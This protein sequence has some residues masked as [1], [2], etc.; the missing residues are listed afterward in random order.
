[1]WSS[2]SMRSRRR[3]SGWSEQWTNRHSP[4]AAASQMR[5]LSQSRLSGGWRVEP[6]I[7]TRG[8]GTGLTLLEADRLGALPERLAAELRELLHAFD[9]RCEVVAGERARLACERG[10]AVREQDLR[11]AD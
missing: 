10:R 4:G 5:A 6:L 8:W 2:R 7:P 3:W 11:L 1:M 9:D